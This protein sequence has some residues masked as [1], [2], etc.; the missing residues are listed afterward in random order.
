MQKFCASLVLASELAFVLVSPV[1]AQSPAQSTAPADAVYLHGHLYPLDIAMWRKESERAGEFFSV[2]IRLKGERQPRPS[3]GCQHV[4]D[5]V[6]QHG[7]AFDDE[8]IPP[9][10]KDIPF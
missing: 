5:Y 4:S 6:N 1:M 9:D 2:S 8:G 7:T 10:D 3:N